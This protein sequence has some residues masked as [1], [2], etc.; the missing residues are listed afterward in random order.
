MVPFVRLFAAA[1]L[2]VVV[3]VFVTLAKLH[4]AVAVNV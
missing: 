3:I 4:I 1:L 2:F